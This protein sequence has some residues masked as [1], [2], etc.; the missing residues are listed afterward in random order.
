MMKLHELHQRRLQVT[1]R[2]VEDALDRIERLLTP[3]G[4]DDEARGVKGGLPAEQSQHLLEEV[5]RLR[6]ALHEF[7]QKFS[8][9]R[10]PLELGNVLNAELSSAW[11]MLENCRPKQMKGYGQPFEEGAREA[12]EESIEQLL[13]LVQG[14]RAKLR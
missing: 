9:E 6:T 12:L 2:L 13:G 11:V 4:R 10:H 8:L 7:A 1:T 14:I 3:D 5:R